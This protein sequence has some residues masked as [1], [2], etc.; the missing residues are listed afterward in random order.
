[1]LK[2]NKHT[3][4]RFHSR[5]SPYWFEAKKNLMGFNPPLFPLVLIRL[6]NDCEICF[7]VVKIRAIC[8]PISYL[9]DDIVGISD[10]NHDNCNVDQACARNHSSSCIILYLLT[11]KGKEQL[12]SVWK[13]QWVMHGFPIDYRNMTIPIENLNTLIG[14]QIATCM[15]KPLSHWRPTK[16][17]QGTI[18][19]S[20][21]W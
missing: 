12:R 1:M 18:L 5:S 10:R 4:R 2:P 6:C 19:S 16:V 14:Y 9:G 20:H 15:P 21:W 8:D 17:A 11:W 3:R 7:F 13:L